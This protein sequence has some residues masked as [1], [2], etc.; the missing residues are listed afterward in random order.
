M[1][2]VGERV[3]NMAA[4]HGIFAPGMVI[5]LEGFYSGSDVDDDTF[6]TV[7]AAPGSS[8]SVIMN[9]R[10]EIVSVIHS[11]YRSFHQIALGSHLN[12]IRILMAEVE[13]KL[14]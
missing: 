4:P 7:P 8:G 3:F 2:R 1:P 5:L 6:Y 9:S 11:A 10:G 13:D 12:Y 14:E